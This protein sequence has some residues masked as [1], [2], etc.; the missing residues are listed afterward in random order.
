MRVGDAYENKAR[1][2]KVESR[3]RSTFNETRDG[4]VGGW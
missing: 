4:W 2:E 3:V 1:N